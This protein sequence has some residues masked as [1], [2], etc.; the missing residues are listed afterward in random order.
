LTSKKESDKDS[1]RDEQSKENKEALMKQ[2]IAAA[3]LSNAHD[4]IKEF[5]QG[6]DTDV[7]SNG[8]AMSG[9]QKQ[10]IAIARALIKKPAVLLLDE[11]TSALDAASE[12]VVQQSIDALAQSKAQTTIIIAHRLSTIR[13]ADKICVINQGQIVEVG[14]HDELI[15]KNGQY[16]DLVR[17]QMTAMESTDAG[18]TNEEDEILR[19]S[20]EDERKN[21]EHHARSRTVSGERRLS[22]AN[23]LQD[24]M[25][26]GAVPS[27]KKEEETNEL[28][29]ED[30]SKVSRQIRE[31]ILQYP[32]LLVVGCV[33]AAIFGAIFPGWGL[34]LANTQDMFYQ[35]DPDQIR[36]DA[37]TYAYYYIL[38]GGVCLFSST[39]QFYG[40]VAVSILKL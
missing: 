38:L 32:V 13:N 14:K 16:A 33:G 35:Y 5:P 4:F 25:E 24:E 20:A 7:G 22:R 30:S 1:K 15:A 10:R 12:R 18:E 11:A 29:K 37:T 34:L 3:K 27:V 40:T 23:S 17:L 6:Y 21:D 31:L 9:G 28:S 8:V 36:E 19:E 26:A 39:A 2:V